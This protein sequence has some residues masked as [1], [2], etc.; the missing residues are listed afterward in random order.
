LDVVI[1]ARFIAGWAEYKEYTL[2]DIDGDGNIGAIDLIIIERSLAGWK[3]Y[4]N[5]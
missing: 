2:N 5:N 4:E 3:G 1:Y